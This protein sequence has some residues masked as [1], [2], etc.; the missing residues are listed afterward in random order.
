[1]INLLVIGVLCLL[2]ITGCSQTVVK[3]IPSSIR[4]L[5]STKQIP[6]RDR[7]HPTQRPYHVMGHTYYPV[8]SSYG[9]SETG[10]ASWYGHQFHGKKTSNG[11]IY[12]MYGTTAA[13]KTLPMNT[14][15]VVKNLENGQETI[16]RVNDRGPFVKGRIIDLSLTAAKELNMDK[17]GTARVKITALGEA[18][19]ASRGGK[20]IE[21]FLPYDFTHGEFFVQIGAFTDKN[22]ADRLK[23]KMLAQGRKAV[24]QMYTIE[25]QKFYRVQVRAGKDITAA[26][27][28]EKTLETQYPG[29]FVIAR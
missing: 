25:D 17:R 18:V 14:F 24:S 15:L 26:H 19:Q 27:Q 3:N 23:D 16:V 4:G 8:P 13:H 1:M 21:R 29:A 11:E 7:I 22:N 9:Y 20:T 2:T 6:E 10:V 12:D 5:E 28:L